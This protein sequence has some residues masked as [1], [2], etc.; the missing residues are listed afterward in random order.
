M[1]AAIAR[2]SRGDSRRRSFWIASLTLAMNT[3]THKKDLIFCF[4]ITER[5]YLG[6]FIFLMLRIMQL[7]IATT[8]NTTVYEGTIDQVNLPTENGTLT[9]FQNHIPSVVKLVPGVIQISSGGKTSKSLS[10]SK[11]IALVDGTMIKITVSV[12]TMQPLAK[13]VELRGNQQLLELKLQKV[14]SFGS[15]EEISQLICELEKVKADIKL[16][17]LYH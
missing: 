13:L 9:V 7:T 12:A 5:L 3:I 2:R 16:A 6:E 10:I 4:F 15:V 1:G 17:E 11:G 14:K 8:Q